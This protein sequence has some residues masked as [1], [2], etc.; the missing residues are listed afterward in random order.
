M[1]ESNY[2]LAIGGLSTRRATHCVAYYYLQDKV[3]TNK[4][5]RNRAEKLLK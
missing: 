2:F 1:P 3:A 4:L 5:P